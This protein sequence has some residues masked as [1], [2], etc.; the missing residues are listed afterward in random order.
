MDSD[1]SMSDKRNKNITLGERSKRLMHAQRLKEIMTKFIKEKDVSYEE[2]DEIWRTF[3]A[4]YLKKN[5]DLD[6]Q[7]FDDFFADWFDLVKNAVEAG[8]NGRFIHTIPTEYIYGQSFG[9]EK[10][11]DLIDVIKNRPF[12]LV[13]KD[14]KSLVGKKPLRDVLFRKRRRSRDQV[15]YIAEFLRFGTLERL[16]FAGFEPVSLPGREFEI[17]C[18][19]RYEMQAKNCIVDRLASVYAKALLMLEE[20]VKFLTCSEKDLFSEDPFGQF[21][22]FA[23]PGDAVRIR[24]LLDML[25]CIKWLPLKEYND[26][27]LFSVP[28]ERREGDVLINDPEFERIIQRYIDIAFRDVLKQEYL[29]ENEWM[30]TER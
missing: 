3:N 7:V 20:H 22:I 5:R 15:G 13:A 23:G 27:I 21:R 9:I 29:E 2:T 25:S 19:E 28:I 12:L 11:N 17:A 4:L 16:G 26:R 10:L 1:G 6:F 14:E 8:R 30:E 18:L 24:E